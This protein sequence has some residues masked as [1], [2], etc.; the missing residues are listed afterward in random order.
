[1]LVKFFKTEAHGNPLGGLNY[2][3]HDNRSASPEV[4]IGNPDVT[5]ELLLQNEF[6]RAYTSG[7]LSFEEKAT[8]VDFE[9]QMNLC[10]SFE[11][12]LLAGLEEDQYDCVWI[13]HTD[14][15]DGRL[16]LNFHIV[17]KELTTNK[18][19]LVYYDKIDRN[20]IDTWKSLQNDIY[21]FSDPNAPDKKRLTAWNNNFRDRREVIKDINNFV[22]DSYVEGEIKNQNDVAELLKSIPDIEI[23]RIT[24]NSISI[25]HPQ[26]DKNIR[27]KGELYE[28]TIKEPATLAAEKENAQREFEKNRNERIES[29]KQK[30][31]QLNHA[32]AEKR[33][34]H[35]AKFERINL[36]HDDGDN[37]IERLSDSEVAREHL[38]RVQKLQSNERKQA[39]MPDRLASLREQIEQSEP[40]EKPVP[41]QEQEIKNRL[42]RI[43]YESVTNQFVHVGRI[44][45]IAT[46]IREAIET[47]RER[48]QELEKIIFF[49]REQKL[50]ESRSLPSVERASEAK[51]VRTMHES[52]VLPRARYSKDSSESGLTV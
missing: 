48:T 19:L 31:N 21:N 14:K 50:D 17:N 49:K 45:R 2:M 30:L 26:F 22:L 24:K 41:D 33:K 52:K 27:L 28:R 1:M 3:L 8:D 32:I 18:R 12:T 16:E 35:F 38:V 20:R 29:N 9:T 40:E 42:E 36:D 7:V 37:G 10:K 34:E 43:K 23:T 25:K 5:R 4:L 13:R 39:P 44:R 46:A 11:K 47:L 51:Q 15:K 6:T